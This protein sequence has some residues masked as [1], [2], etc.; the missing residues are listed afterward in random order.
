[1]RAVGKFDEEMP[2]RRCGLAWWART[3]LGGARC[4]VA[5]RAM[6]YLSRNEDTILISGTEIISSL[7]AATG[8]S[9]CGSFTVDHRLMMSSDRQ[10]LWAT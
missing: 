1:M 7:S 10:V 2:T 4:C 8:L 3:R 9:N 5:T 6:E